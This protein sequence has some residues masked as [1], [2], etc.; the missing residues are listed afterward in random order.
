MPFLLDHLKFQFRG[1][2]KSVRPEKCKIK[3]GINSLRGKHRDDICFPRLNN[4]S[5]GR[6]RN[7]T[8]KFDQDGNFP[9]RD[10][11]FETGKAAACVRD[12]L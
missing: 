8:Y 9:S 1:L 12:A 3:A 6:T 4:P 5:A 2:E 11:F 10:Y 7:E